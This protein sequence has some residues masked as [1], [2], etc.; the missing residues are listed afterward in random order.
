MIRFLTVDDVP[1]AMALSTAAGWNQ[2]AED[3]RR[4][5]ALE[6]EACFGVE[7]NGQIVATTTLLCYNTELAWV[8]MVLTHAEHQRRGLAR[9]LVSAALD[10]AR[11]RGIRSVK[12][13]ATDQGRPLYASLGFIDEQEIERWRRAPHPNEPSVATLAAGPIPMALDAA[14]FGADRSRFLRALPAPALRAESGYVMTR[15]GSRARYVGPC[16]TDIPHTAPS[17]VAAALDEGPWFWDLLP[18]NRTA[19]ITATELGFEPVRRLMRMRLG[20]AVDSR[21]DQVI[22][23]AG[24]EAG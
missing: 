2:T 18:A 11:Q 8:G 21:G 3:W 14:A 19:R 20:A 1:A 5:I 13:D 23:I 17:L 7:S 16:V 9:R 24:F 22:A 12:L 15:P 6:P 10:T 4:I